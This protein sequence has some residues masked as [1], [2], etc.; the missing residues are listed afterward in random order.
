MTKFLLILCL[1]ILIGALGW[2]YY[3]RMY[4]P[5]L[6]QRT[7]EVA[8]DA[9]EKATASAKEVGEYVGDAAII[10]LIKGK[11]MMDPDFSVLAIGVQ[12]TNGHVLLTGSVAS[13]KLLT[14]AVEIAEQTKGVTGVTSKL[15]VKE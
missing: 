5:A 12:C 6:V 4:Q 15:T 1:G 7:Q 9:K 11:Y 2:H 10:A 13:P 14:R 3:Q 8:S